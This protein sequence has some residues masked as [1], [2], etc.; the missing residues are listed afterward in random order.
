MATLDTP[1]LGY[2][3]VDKTGKL[4]LYDPTVFPLTETIQYDNPFNFDDGS[5]TVF[6]DMKTVNH[7]KSMYEYEF[8]DFGY[9]V[10]TIPG[11]S[12]DSLAERLQ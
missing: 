6:R 5:F 12:E 2:G 9:R 1:I 4:L 11:I 3:I 8:D 7:V 10:V